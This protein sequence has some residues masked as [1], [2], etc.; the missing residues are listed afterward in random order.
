MTDLPLGWLVRSLGAR[1]QKEGRPWKLQIYMFYIWVVHVVK[2]LVTCHA[3]THCPNLWLPRKYKLFRS[4]RA[5]CGVLDFLKTRI[6][7]HMEILDQEVLTICDKFIKLMVPKCFLCYNLSINSTPDSWEGLLVV[8]QVMIVQWT[9]YLVLNLRPRWCTH[10][11]NTLSKSD[12]AIS[13]MRG[14]SY[15]NSSNMSSMFNGLQAL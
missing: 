4:F 15:D 8:F 10:G 6:M 3:W 7:K 9:I 13:D 14:Q 1:V 11:R 12:I 2:L 5:S